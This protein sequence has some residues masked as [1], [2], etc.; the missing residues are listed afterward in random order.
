MNASLPPG[1]AY[2]KALRT[3]KTWRPA[4]PDVR[5]PEA[6]PPFP[7]NNRRY[8][9]GISCHRTKGGLQI[10]PS[11]PFVPSIANPSSRKSPAKRWGL[12]PLCPR[13][14][15]AAARTPL[16]LI[17]IPC[18]LEAPR[19]LPSEAYVPSTLLRRA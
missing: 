2:S 14:I 10:T 6:H 11:N 5:D 12:A 7:F 19:R 9:D 15:L 16:G 8:S 4:R 17:S 3:K 13:R 1:L 18:I